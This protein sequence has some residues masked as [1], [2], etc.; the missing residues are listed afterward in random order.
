M[1]ASDLF[2]PSEAFAE[3]TPDPGPAA[4]AAPPAAPAEG[5][6]ETEGVSPR[7]GEAPVAEGAEGTES[8]DGSAEPTTDDTASTESDSVVAAPGSSLF[9]QSVSG[10]DSETP[11]AS[12][13]VV[14]SNSALEFN[15]YTRGDIFIGKVPGFATGE[16]K[17]AYGE[18]ALKVGI[19]KGEFGGA[20]AE[21]R[22]R[23]G[24][25]GEDQRL[26]LDLREA[27]VDA[28]FGD[29]DLRLGHQIIVWGRADAFNPTN[30]VTPSDLRIR[31]PNEDD[32]RVGNVGARAFYNLTPVRLEAVWMPIYSPVE[33][34][35]VAFPDYVAFAE[36]DFPDPELA[37]GLYAGRVHLELAAFEMSVSYLHGYAPLPG[38]AFSDFTIGPGAEIRI[39][40]TAYT[41]DVIGFDFS[42]AIGDDLGVRAEAAYRNP[43]D[44]DQIYA[45]NPDVQYV[46]GLDRSF[47]SVSAIL[48]YMGRY[49]L[50]WEAAPPP[51]ANAVS[52]ETLVGFTMIS[53]PIR[54]TVTTS[55]N[56]ELARRNETLF[57]QLAEIQHLASLRLEWLTA[58]DTVALSAIAL[59]NFTTEEWLL[60]PKLEY[61]ITDDMAA[62]VGAEIYAG[63]DETL[64]GLI[65]APLSAGYGE[66]KVAF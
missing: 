30:N 13:G 32:R 50:D 17:A 65:D 55:V 56:S 28:Y 58:H 25:Q 41:H 24:R 27:Y 39:A 10:G 12:G 6:G 42:T 59:M 52:P 23:F 22:F 43:T 8:A 9:A 11:A 14:A 45:P 48:Q 49:V 3:Q 20:F 38:L 40:R 16:I 36:P 2:F 15:G 18:L 46:L 66:L 51:A 64:L 57:Q 26:F 34:P 19:K 5:T 37:K 4:S 53:D 54:E 33:L 63:P 62:T 35:T 29:L 60:L 7:E 31:S 61:R 21:P 1:T 47:G 44:P